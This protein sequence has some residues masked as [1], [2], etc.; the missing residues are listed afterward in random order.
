MFRR[1]FLENLLQDALPSKYLYQE[2]RFYPVHPLSISIP[3]A[4]LHKGPVINYG[5]GGLQN[6]KM[7]VPKH[8]APPPTP[9]RQSKKGEKTFCTAPSVWL[10]LK[11][12]KILQ[13]H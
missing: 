13:K 6:G 10:K 8:F 3:T 1:F 9:L 5:E 7:A 12:F 2:I 11:C 4:H